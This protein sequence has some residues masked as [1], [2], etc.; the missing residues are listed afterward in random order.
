M[1]IPARWYNGGMGPNC[2]EMI[3][4]T[5]SLW[6]TLWTLTTQKIVSGCDIAGGVCYFLWDRDH[7]TE[8]R[9]QI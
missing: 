4:Q 1:I 2:L 6:F 9:I 8:S 5:I 3:C 7:P